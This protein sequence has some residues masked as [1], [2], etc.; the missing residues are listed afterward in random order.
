MSEC[1][2][3]RC[4]AGAALASA[5]P[6]AIATHAQTIVLTPLTSD[7]GATTYSPYVDHPGPWQAETS[8]HV[9]AAGADVPPFEGDVTV[10]D[11]IVMTV[12]AGH[13]AL[14]R[15]A[16]LLLA[17]LPGTGVV[18]FSIFGESAGASL[19]CSFDASLGAASVPPAALALLERDEL[20]LSA[21]HEN[22]VEVEAGAWRV[23]MAGVNSA[24]SADHTDYTLTITIH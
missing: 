21:S 12:P 14:T 7:G 10:P 11:P 5:G 20:S 13:V 4:D 15:G 8:L 24:L 9:Q 3:E 19:A 23:R 17:W 1:E 22:P 2:L 18:R 6:I 16:P